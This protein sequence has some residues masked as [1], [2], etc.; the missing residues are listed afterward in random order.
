MLA[1]ARL[2]GHRARCWA[3]YAYG[4]VAGKRHGVRPVMT[5]T[6]ILCPTDFSEASAH[7]IKLAITIARWYKRLQGCRGRCGRGDRELRNS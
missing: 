1:R 2:G 5:I 7:A 4:G 6:R 3:G